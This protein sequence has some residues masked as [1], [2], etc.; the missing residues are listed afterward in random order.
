MIETSS[1][2]APKRRRFSEGVR[3]RR[4]ASR[5][6][7]GIHIEGGGRHFVKDRLE[8]TGTR[9]TIDGAQ[10]MLRTRAVYLNGQ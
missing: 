9:W 2:A 8:Q 5:L 10:A 3:A 1:Q 6:E 7:R 4:G